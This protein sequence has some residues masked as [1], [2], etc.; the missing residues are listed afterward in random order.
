MAG[1]AGD[2]DADGDVDLS[3]RAAFVAC[4]AGPEA[5]SP[6]EGCTPDEFAAADLDEDGDV[7]LADFTDF[8][9]GFPGP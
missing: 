2:L 9:P 8:V 3:D 6:P 1:P 7:D 4:L 5:S